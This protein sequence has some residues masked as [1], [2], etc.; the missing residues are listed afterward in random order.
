VQEVENGFRSVAAQ[1]DRPGRATDK[2]ILNGVGDD[3]RIRKPALE[4]M[5]TRRRQ[6]EPLG[7]SGRR[8]DVKRVVNFAH[9]EDDFRRFHTSHPTPEGSDSAERLETL[10]KAPARV[11][12]VCEDIVAH[13]AT[14]IAPLGQKAMVVAYDR[15]LCV[16]YQDVI[17]CLL[18]ARP[19][20]R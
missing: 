6:A 20:G 8:S 4:P 18:D 2:H 5:R 19:D 11:R 3:G 1:R 7:E 16:R 15:D 12:R 14:R 13:Y 9:L 17:S 10:L